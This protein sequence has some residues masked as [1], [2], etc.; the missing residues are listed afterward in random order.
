MLPRHCALRHACHP[1][2]STTCLA[3]YNHFERLWGK[4]F[5]CHD[6]ILIFIELVTKF[7]DHAFHVVIGNPAFVSL[8]RDV[9]T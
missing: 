5:F 4:V 6:G 7:T 3:M 9:T 8:A 1:P 2:A